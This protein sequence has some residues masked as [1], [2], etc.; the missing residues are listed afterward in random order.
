MVTG[1]RAAMAAGRALWHCCKGLRSR[2]SFVG[3]CKMVWMVVCGR[4]PGAVRVV[5]PKT[6]RKCRV[7][8]S[9]FALSAIPCS[10][11]TRRYQGMPQD[12]MSHVY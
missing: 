7:S 2:S 8:S 11:S 10:T 6:C 3:A 12:D 1:D 9:A 4:Q 5:A